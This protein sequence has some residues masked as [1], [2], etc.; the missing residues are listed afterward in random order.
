MTIWLL[1][2]TPKML[3]QKAGNIEPR[4]FFV[5]RLSHIPSGLLDKFEGAEVFGL[6]IGCNSGDLTVALKKHLTDDSESN[7]ILHIL[8]VDVDP[9]LVK[10]A[11]RDHK[12]LD[13]VML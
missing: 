8:G 3:K 2:V 6:D 1:I 7:K 12:S 5:Y 4:D 11:Q 10:V 9:E 13:K